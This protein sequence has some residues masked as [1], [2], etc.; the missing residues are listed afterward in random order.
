MWFGEYF[1]YE[2]ESPDFY[3]TEVSGIPFGLMGEM[4]Q[5]GGNAWRGM[6]YGM[7]NRMPYQDKKPDGIWKVWDDFGIEGSSMIGY[8]VE[9]NPIK[10]NN[11]RVL[12]TVYKKEAKVLISIASWDQKDVDVKLNIDWEQL[13]I[14]EDGIKIY[15]PPIKDFQ[16]EKT[17]KVGESI[18]VEKNK[19][20][21]IILE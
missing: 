6:L 13:G 17:F 2:K 10:T 16:E 15:A 14:K 9:K 3:L 21:L 18:S 12:V 20:W 19:G 1:D 4:L 7:T 8:W 5:D 11:D